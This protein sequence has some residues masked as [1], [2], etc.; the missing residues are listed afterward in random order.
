[1]FDHQNSL[2]LCIEFSQKNEL[3]RLLHYQVNL[4]DEALATSPSPPSLW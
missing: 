1:M 4:R 2:F 3:H